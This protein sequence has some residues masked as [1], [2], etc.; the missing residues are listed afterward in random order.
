[1]ILGVNSLG[2]SPLVELQEQSK[3]GGIAVVQTKRVSQGI[4][5]YERSLTLDPNLAESRV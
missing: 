5:E 4:A 2:Y 1:L 3:E